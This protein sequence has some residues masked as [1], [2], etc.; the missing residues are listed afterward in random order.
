MVALGREVLG[1]NGILGDFNVAKA[2]CDIEA[3]YSY[4]VRKGQNSEIH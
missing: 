3:F 2:F 1:G 4:E